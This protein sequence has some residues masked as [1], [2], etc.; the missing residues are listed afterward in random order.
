MSRASVNVVAVEDSSVTYLYRRLAA[1]EARVRATV[2]RRRAVDSD[3]DDRFRG[4]YISDSHVDHMLSRADSIV[5]DPPDPET[6]SFVAAADADADAAERAGA[7]IRLRRLAQ[8]FA[9]ADVDIEILLVVLAPDLDPRFE[10]LYAYLNDDVSRRRATIGLAL[11][12][13]GLPQGAGA[14]RA[15]FNHDSPLVRQGLL[16][17]EEMDRPFLTRALR[18]PDRVIGHVLGDDTPDPVVRSLVT[19]CIEAD[20]AAADAIAR[21]LGA[22]IS[23]C[24]VRERLGAAGFSL[25]ATAFSRAGLLRL[26]LDLSRLD[27]S[28]DL[29]DVAMAACREARLSGGGLIIGPVEAAVER[30]ATAIRSFAEASVPMV[31]VG[32]RGW[33]PQWS[34]EVPILVDAPIPAAQTRADFWRGALNDFSPSGIDPA[35]ST[36]QF[37]LTPEQVQRAAQA[38]QQIARSED[39]PLEVPDLYAG[40]RAQNAAGLE[41]LARRIEPKVGWDDLVLPRTAMDQLKE[42]TGRVRHREMVLDEWG[43]GRRAHG[44]GISVLF[45]GESGTGKTMSAEVVAGDLGLDLYVIDLSTV[46]DKYVGE[47]EKNL[48]RIFTE[49]DRVNG[50]LL[51]DEADAIFGKRSDVR[52]AHDR[53]ANVETA[54]LLS[55]M[56]RFDGLAILTT[57]LRS[58]ID[59]AFARRLVAI[60]DFALPDPEYRRRLWELNLDGGIPVA[61]DID[62]DFLAQAFRISGGN[63]RNIALAAAHL[64]ATEETVVGMAHVIRATEREYLKLGHLC[65]ADEFGPYYSLIDR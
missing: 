48:E 28:N 57:N 46:V 45:A 39:R 13:C 36:A 44:R 26:A 18:V 22:G 6:A 56:E 47:T 14:T 24:Y 16:I 8:S 21:G 58:N 3:P 51:F 30:G 19:N 49:A 65:V 27:T 12:L 37:R 40:A 43:M 11:E 2:A 25:A 32:A 53:Y 29:N 38:A 64:A 5:A 23:L 31:I 62:L 4:L 10:R 42:L 41:R 15:R 34:R 60:V 35:R 33:D 54:Y 61:A 1:V 17:V 20:F 52:D 9:L 63:I 50:V 59:E 55:R 7:D